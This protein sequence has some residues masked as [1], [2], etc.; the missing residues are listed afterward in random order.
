VAAVTVSIRRVSASTGYRYLMQTVAAGDGLR[1]ASSPLT[2]YYAAEGTPPG[3]WIGAGLAGLDSGRGLTIGATVTEA[4]LFNLL[5][6]GADPVTGQPLGRAPNRAAAA[7][8]Q[9]VAERLHALPARL[10]AADRDRMVEQIKA[11]ERDREA[12]IPHAVAGF[13]LTFSVPKSVSAIWAVADRDLQARIVEAHHAAIDDVIVYAER[14]V[15]ATRKGANG[16][17]QVDVQGVVAAAFDHWDSR[18]NDPHLHTHVVVA[19]RVQPAGEEGWRTLDSRA[20]YRAVVALS[21]LHQG[22]VMDRVSALLGVGWDGRARR[23]SDVPQY[24]VTGVSDALRAEFSQRAEG[25]EAEK[26]RLLADYRSRHGRDPGVKA[27]LQ[28]RQQATLATR[29]DK[30]VHSLADLTRVWRE[31]ARKY[32][33]DDPARWIS[34]LV[35]ADSPARADLAVDQIQTVAERALTTVAD[36]HATF[37]RWNL[38]AEVHRQ[39]QPVRFANAAARE[40]AASRA[41]DSALGLAVMVSAPELASTPT[42]FQRADGSIQFR[43]RGADKY[44]TAATLQAEDRLLAAGRET[45]GP[46]L[47]ASIIGAIPASLGL[48]DEQSAAVV[49]IATSG[50]VLDELVGAAGTGKTTTMA[51][52][53]T[54]WQHNHGA[55]S[56]IGLAPSA[57]AAQALADELGIATENTAKW[58]AENDLEAGRLR[59]IDRLRRLMHRPGSHRPG[60]STRVA[61]AIRSVETEVEQWRLRPGQLVIVDE[62]SLA[63]TRSLDAVVGRARRA[64]AKVLLVGDPFQL[65]A[66]ESG[67]ALAMLVRD[68]DVVPELLDIHRFT[69]DWERP[70]STGLRRGDTA[71]IDA[72]GRRGRLSAGERADMLDRAYLGWVRDREAGRASVLIAPDAE[73]VAELNARARTDLVLAGIVDADGVELSDGTTAGVGDWV[74]TRLNDR[75]LSTGAG[76]VKNGDR[77][78]VASVSSKGAVVVQRLNGT[79]RVALP[80]AY[81]AEHLELGYATTAYRSQGQTVE[82]AHALVTGPGMTR[83]AFYVAMTRGRHAN[84]AYVA[85][86]HDP[87]QNTAHGPMEPQ[88][89]RTV[90]TAVLG[91]VGAYQSAHDTIRTE[92]ET[93]SGWPQLVAEY[94]TIAASAQFDRWWTAISGALPA[95]LSGKELAESPA[96]PAL[97]TALRRAEAHGLNVEGVLPKL[98]KSREL[99]TA[100]DVAAVLHDRIERWV[101]KESPWRPAAA[102]RLIAG[103][104]PVAVGIADPDTRRALDERAAL[105]E[106][107]AWQLAEMAVDSGAQWVRQLGPVPLKSA[108]RQRFMRAAATIAA[109]RDLCGVGSP[110]VRPLPSQQAHRADQAF[111]MRAL[112]DARRAADTASSPDADHHPCVH[113]EGPAR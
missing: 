80:P 12:T 111:A 106:Q 70:A 105:L 68:R 47:P 75:T 1:D 30:H 113:V 86:D 67:G 77:W 104:H 39:L 78:R 24:E 97:M 59:R 93:A 82:T 90:I 18:S 34:R 8:S 91:N 101:V 9:R 23:H 13:D 69:N 88:T 15:F 4:Q 40:Q 62:A 3:R 42:Q 11:E 5:G 25:I 27:I 17:A 49:E 45:T 60:V 84:H 66:V 112:A 55:G 10:D 36:K 96:L 44:T 43:H 7:Y 109:Y 57:T 89:A 65:S 94:D 103:H 16:V 51:G 52:L 95:T 46:A 14:E 31:R 100:Q 79:G 108:A 102:G 81:V 71:A 63:S 33:G 48:S 38:A 83:E 54:A 26:N 56:V 85:T 98:V 99:G 21:E 32:V 37:T 76:W 72:Y 92:L 73:T 6:M 35:V 61:A 58:L 107:R 22:L 29:P 50:R 19:N 64:G 74:T 2:R 20:L 53:L 41:V 110:D 87:D 28:L